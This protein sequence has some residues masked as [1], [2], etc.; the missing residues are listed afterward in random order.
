MGM[1]YDAGSK[2]VATLHRE[3]PVLGAGLFSEVFDVGAGTVVKVCRSI[4]GTY[5]WLKYA[6][7]LTLAGIRRDLVPEVHELVT[8]DYMGSTG[9]M[10]VMRK[11]HC[12]KERIKYSGETQFAC[13]DWLPGW[14]EAQGLFDQW[15]RDVG[16]ARSI[17]VNDLHH[18]NVMMDDY[19]N[20]VV[21]DPSSADACFSDWNY[22]NFELGCNEH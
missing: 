19:G 18:G 13:G 21:T 20:W 6:Q 16:M 3:R 8:V 10:A 9:Y 14:D 22:P 11:Y 12:A 15:C 2:I 7:A 17:R 1:V 5:W 4:E